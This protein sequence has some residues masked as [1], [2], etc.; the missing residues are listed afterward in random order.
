MNP[1][2]FIG[3]MSKNIVD[4]IIDYSNENDVKIGIIPSRR[5]VEF[6]G[7][8]VND[9][10][11]GDFC[12]YVKSKTNNILL[13]RDHGGPSQGNTEDDGLE[14]FIEDCK[15]FDVV[16]VDVWKKHKNYDEGL[17]STIDFII[18]G[19]EM[20]PYLYYEVG[21]EEAIRQFTPQ[22]LDQLLSDLKSRLPEEI[23][24][25]IL[26]AV[27]QS[28]TALKGNTNIGTYS[29]DRLIKMLEVVSKHGLISKEHNGDYIDD[30]TLRNK[31]NCGL[32]TI[33]IAPEFGQLETKVILEEIGDNQ[34]LLDKFYELCYNSKR[35]VKWVSNDFVPIENKIE[36]INICG[37]Y[38][39]S[40]PKFIE[41]KKLLS[42]DID[43]KIKNK[44]KQRIDRFM[45]NIEA[46]QYDILLKYFEYF[47]NKDLQNLSNIF[48]DRVSLTDWDINAV[49]KESVMN[50]NKNIFDSVNTINVDVIETF[51]KGNKFSCQL[52]I[53]INDMETIEVVDVIEFNEKNKIIS[54]KAYKG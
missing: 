24:S 21:T 32:E 42:N 20:N 39:F 41:I 47:S 33:N 27:V 22:E 6:D 10:K 11:T 5:Q 17:K 37:H 43:V 19:Y 18:R 16:H 53:T 25:K 48:D 54:V 40:D 45:T 13:V 44:I 4:A 31:F 36:L 52:V 1:K 46:K 7:G 30:D 49:G 23:N 51:K 2:L 50:A 3:P 26:Y 8:Y 28:G 38:V 9:W 29:N 35:W 15:N 12:S 14:S 34:V